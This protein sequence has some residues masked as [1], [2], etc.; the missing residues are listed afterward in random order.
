MKKL[1]I[2][3]VALC[4]AVGVNAI[5]SANV[6]GYNG[7]SLLASGSKMIAPSF[8]TVNGASTFKLSDLKGTGYDPYDEDEEEGGANGEIN[9][10]VLDAAG[11]VAKDGN[12]RDME[13]HWYDLGTVKAAGWYYRGGSQAVDAANV[14]LDAGEGLWVAGKAGLTLQYAGQV[15]TANIAVPLRASGSKATGNMMA[16]DLKLSQIWGSGYDP[17]DE[18][19][20]EGGANGEINVRVLDAAGAV[21]KDGNGT[22]MEFHWYDLG[23]VKAAGWYYRGGSQAVDAANVTITSGEGLW[24]AGKGGLYLNFTAPT[25]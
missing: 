9:V 21:A 1:M 2:G 8:L 4:A 20:E 14:I 12:G 24:V 7:S 23:T 18:D 16:V 3:A 22:D 19:E 6:V 17:Y 11:A 10:R 25:L 5:E 13:F 15:G